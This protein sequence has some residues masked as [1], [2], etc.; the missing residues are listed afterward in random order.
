[1]GERGC[2]LSPVAVSSGDDRR[3]HQPQTKSAEQAANKDE[4]GL[5]KEDQANSESENESAT[6]GPS[7]PVSS[8]GDV[9]HVCASRDA[10]VRPLTLT[11]F[12]DQSI[13]V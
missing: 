7:A 2:T 6:R 12:E 13:D 3:D 1:M 4:R 10:S 5:L 11:R 8:L 9:I